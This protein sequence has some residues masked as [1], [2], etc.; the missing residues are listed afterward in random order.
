[1]SCKRT[2][3]FDG[4]LRSTQGLEFL[5]VYS[6]ESSGKDLSWVTDEYL[7]SL[8]DPTAAAGEPSSLL[9]CV[10]LCVRAV[11]CVVCVCVCVCM[12]VAL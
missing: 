9:C 1:M 11:V 5:L 12:R 6:A 2:L 4:L 7:L 10:G 8:N 3:D